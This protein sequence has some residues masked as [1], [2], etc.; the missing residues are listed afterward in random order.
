MGPLS[1]RPSLRIIRSICL[2][3]GAVL[4]LALLG[5]HPGSA[6]EEWFTMNKDYSAQRYVDLDQITPENVAGLR[7]VCEVELNQ[8]VFFTSGLV[9]AG[10][11]LFVTTNRQTVALD[12]ATCA[13]RWRHVLNFN[14]A[15]IGAS[16]RGVGYMDGKVFRGTPDGRVMAFDATSGK[17]LWDVQA[18]DT[19]KHEMFPSAPIVWRG[20]VFIDIAFSDGGIAGRL[21]ALDAESGQEIWRFSTTMGFNAGGGFW[22]S[23]SLDPATGEIFGGVANPFPDWSRDLAPNDSH[24]ELN[25]FR[26]RGHRQAQLAL[27]GHSARRARLGPRLDAD[28][29]QGRVGQGPARYRRQGRA[30]LRDRPD[31]SRDRL[32]HPG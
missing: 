29:V 15:P 23:Y 27:P 24:D 17:L 14:E 10:G 12:A 20:K 32:Q 26:G 13:V 18:A 16:A 4:V 8:P 19:Q 3:V 21:L 9:M 28:T 1:I 2:K 30:G 11:A 6:A 25:Y 22:A 31:H 7:E 5:T